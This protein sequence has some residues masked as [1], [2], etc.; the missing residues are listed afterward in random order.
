MTQASLR[1]DAATILVVDD[2]RGALEF[3]EAGLCS[4]DYRVIAVPSATA[5]L[6]LLESRCDVDLLFTDIVM[7][8]D[9]DGFLLARRARQLRPSIRILYATAYSNLRAEIISRYGKVMKKPYRIAELENEIREALSGGGPQEADGPAPGSL[10]CGIR[11]AFPVSV[12]I[13]VVGYLVL[14]HLL[15]RAEP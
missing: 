13:W 11:L 9:L 1:R 15:F 8:D 10:L 7:P 12:L 2:E 6:Q 14:Y 3:A 4:L 5:A